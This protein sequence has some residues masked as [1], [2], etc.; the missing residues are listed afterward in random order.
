VA[1]RHIPPA[2]ERIVE[3]CLA[4]APAARFKSADDL[5]F[6]LEAPSAHSGSLPVADTLPPTGRRARAWT[7]AAVLVAAGISAGALGASAY[8]RRA[9]QNAEAI[10]FTFLPPPGVT[11]SDAAPARR[12]AISP[13]G[14]HIAFT[15]SGQDGRAMLWLRSLD[16]LTWRHRVRSTGR[17]IRSWVGMLPSRYDRGTSAA[18]HQ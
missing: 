7:I 2:V 3:R 9:P 5:A 13:N 11:F 10:R 17:T 18:L 15:A 1:E 12:V 8:L 14:R 6:A 16:T 4:K